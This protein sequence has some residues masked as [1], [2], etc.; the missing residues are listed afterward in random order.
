MNRCIVLDQ[1]LGKDGGFSKNRLLKRL[2]LSMGITGT[3]Q[4]EFIMCISQVNDQKSMGAVFKNEVIS[5]AFNYVV[6]H[7]QKSVR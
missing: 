1:I 2:A 4:N 5:I 3:N 6:Q 7:E